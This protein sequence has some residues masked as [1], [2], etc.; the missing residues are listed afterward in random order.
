MALC[1]AV[2]GLF[3]EQYLF[4]PKTIVWQ[5]DSFFFILLI[6]VSWQY[7]MRAVFVYSL[8][9]ALIDFGLNVL[10]PPTFFVIS[11]PVDVA[12][13]AP[14]ATIIFF[15]RQTGRILSFLV[16][17][18]VITSLTAA[19]RKQRHELTVANRELAQHAGMLEQL[20]TSRERNRISRELHDTVAHTLSGLTVQLE[21]L[22]T[23]WK[24]MPVQAKSMVDKM[25]SSTR[26][27]LDETRRTLKNLRAAPLEELG[28]ALAVQSLAQEAARRGNFDL[29]VKIDK[30]NLDLANDVQQAFYRVSQEALENVVRHAKAKTVEL[31]LQKANKR[32]ELVIRDDGKGFRSDRRKAGGRL[33]LTLMKERAELIGAEFKIESTPAG[34]TTIRMV[35]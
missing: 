7:D 23:A 6:L 13:A 19:Q 5:A 30:K 15:G 11:G 25:L 33:G 3:I 31:R 21:A 18:F 2:A 35:Y 12:R 26:S 14:P 29:Q 32:L 8:A 10:I 1:I 24:R 9:I 27:G 17:G 20:G 34:G 28:L 16:V 4:T 22:Q